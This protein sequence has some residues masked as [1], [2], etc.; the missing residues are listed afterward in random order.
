MHDLKTA[1]EGLGGEI[2]GPDT[3]GYRVMGWSRDMITEF[4]L[5]DHTADNFHFALDLIAMVRELRPDLTITIEIKQ[6]ITIEP[7]GASDNG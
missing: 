1:L 5:F 6:S 4:P 3:Q 2:T 7:V